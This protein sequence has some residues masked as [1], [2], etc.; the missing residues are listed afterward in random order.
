MNFLLTS[1]KKSI[2][3]RVALAEPITPW[4]Q[5]R[6]WVIPLIFFSRESN[7]PTVN[8]PGAPLGA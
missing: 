5:V 3:K 6:R 1:T 7:L 2:S 8:I 4:E